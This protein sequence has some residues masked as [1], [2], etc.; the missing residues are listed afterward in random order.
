M[1]HALASEKEARDVAEQARETPSPEYGA[2]IMQ[3]QT[4]ARRVV[5]FWDE[6]DVVATPTLAMP[7]VPIGWTWEETDGDPLVAFARQTLFTPFTPLLNV[8]GQPATSLPLHVS[9][10]GLPVGVQFVGRPFDEATLIRLAAQIEAAGRF[11]V[12]SLGNS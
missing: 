8:T 12:P 7:P 1:T 11:S 2:A 9:E 4:I 5:A 6:Y 3:L 10:D